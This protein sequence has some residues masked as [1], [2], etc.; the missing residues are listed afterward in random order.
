MYIRKSQKK[1]LYVGRIWLKNT[2]FYSTPPVAAS[3]Q[4]LKKKPSI[5]ESFSVEIN[6]I[7]MLLI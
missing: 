5:A 3:N 7:T 6:L 4:N 2:S 1:I